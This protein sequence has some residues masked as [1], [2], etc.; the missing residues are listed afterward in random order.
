MC[1]LKKGC[2]FGCQVHHA[3]YCLLVAY[4]TERT[5]VLDS[6]GWRYA[7][8]GGWESM[9]QPLSDTCTDAS[10]QSVHW[11]GMFMMIAV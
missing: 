7:G 5:L 9:F 2:G 6:E 1:D 4:A 10:G 11:A 3:A 8:G